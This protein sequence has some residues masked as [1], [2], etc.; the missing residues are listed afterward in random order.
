M[1]FKPGESGT[2]WF[3]PRLGP[4]IRPAMR[5]IGCVDRRPGR[6]APCR[7]GSGLFSPRLAP[8]RQG[9]MP[10]RRRRRPVRVSIVTASKKPIP[11]DST[12]RP[13]ARLRLRLV[14]GSTR[15]LMVVA[16]EGARPMVVAIDG[17]PSELFQPTRDTVS[18]R[19]RRADSTCCSTFRATPA[20]PCA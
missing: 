19:A 14:N 6:T 20:S 15:R 12:F 10:V 5:P 7:P 9:A 2:A 4:P 13:G 17:Q 11:A 18:D 8:G 1:R 3:R 16:C